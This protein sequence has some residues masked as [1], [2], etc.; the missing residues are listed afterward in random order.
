[1]AIKLAILNDKAR[2][3][4]L[5]PNNNS[6]STGD[7]A[8]KIFGLNVINVSGISD[9]MTECRKA[10]EAGVKLVIDLKLQNSKEAD[11]KKI[12]QILEKNFESL[13]VVLNISAIHSE[14]YNRKILGRYKEYLDGVVVT[15]MDQCMNFASIIN[16]N[17]T[18]L[19]LP[20]IFFGTGEMIPD[21]IEGASA[22]RL[23]A[24]TFKF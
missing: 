15:F 17:Y 7:F 4:R 14:A 11:S 21:D 9:L 13:D 22:E 18:N 20:L 5:R 8:T 3:I 24:G 16:L 10:K 19:N 2:I 6:G 23:L 1:M 12:L